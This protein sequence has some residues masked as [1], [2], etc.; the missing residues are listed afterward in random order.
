MW[1]YCNGFSQKVWQRERRFLSGYDFH[2][3]TKGAG[4]DGLHLHSQIIQAVA[5]EYATRRKQAQKRKLRWRVSGGRR[6][7]LGRIPFK[8]SAIRDRN[9][10]VFFAGTALSLWDSYGLA[11]HTFGAGNISEDA[12]GRWYLKLTIKIEK[13]ARPATGL[14]EKSVGI[15]RLKEFAATSDGNV[16]SLDRHYRKLEQ[17]LAKA[18]RAIRKA[19]NHTIGTRQHVARTQCQ[20]PCGFA[21]HRQRV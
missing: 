12:R 6:S 3:S 2:P 1:N 16:I 14:A 15:V 20:A 7:A 8:A 5:V 10:Q 11:N 4:K 9:G 21:S 18:Q 17:E 13:T 19:R